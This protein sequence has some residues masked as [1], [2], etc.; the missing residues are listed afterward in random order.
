M[1][2]YAIQL[3]VYNL[4]LLY[5]NNIIIILSAFHV[6]LIMI[7]INSYLYFAVFKLYTFTLGF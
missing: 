7:I 6:V 3:S 2:I 4:L 1:C 5:Y